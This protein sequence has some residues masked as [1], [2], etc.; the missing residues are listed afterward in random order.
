MGNR[1]LLFLGPYVP[2]SVL[3]GRQDQGGPLPNEGRTTFP[4]SYPK[5]SWFL[6]GGLSESPLDNAINQIWVNPLIRSRMLLD[7]RGYVHD[8]TG[9]FHGRRQLCERRPAVAAIIGAQFH[10]KVGIGS[11]FQGVPLMAGLPA[12]LPVG[13][14]PKALVLLRPVLVP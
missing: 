8:L 3:D 12:G 7:H 13:R 10:D 6:W 5:R 1:N 4:R 2:R 9:L 14:P 11:H